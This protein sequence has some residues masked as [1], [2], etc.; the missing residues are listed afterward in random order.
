MP[1]TALMMTISHFLGTALFILMTMRPV[2]PVQPH[3]QTQPWW[4]YL[5]GW[6]SSGEAGDSATETGS[7]QHSCICTDIG[8]S[9]RVSKAAARD[10]EAA[11]S[12]PAA[13]P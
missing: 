12:Y 8:S 7:G 10:T 4:L 2:V 5:R 9:G 11:G 3:A 6:P 13:V 1:L